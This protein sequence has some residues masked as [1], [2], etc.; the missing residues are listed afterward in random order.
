MKEIFI[1]L[2]R[3]FCAVMGAVVFIFVFLLAS[4]AAFAAGPIKVQVVTTSY[5]VPS[6]KWAQVTA[7]VIQGGSFTIGGVVALSSVNSLRSWTIL[8]SDN[9]AVIASTFQTSQ[10]YLSVYTGADNSI[11]STPANTVHTY[12]GAFNEGTAYSE[13]ITSESATYNL[14]AGTVINGSGTWRATVELY[15]R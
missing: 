6:G 5:T 8:A 2:F 4:S 13:A 1:H 11:P 3:T 7:H 15:E 9:L 14:P 12:N 10:K